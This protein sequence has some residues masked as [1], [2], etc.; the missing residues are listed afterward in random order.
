MSV[1]TEDLRGEKTTE[2]RQIGQREN[3]TEMETD[4]AAINLRQDLITGFRMSPSTAQLLRTKLLK[5]PLSTPSDW[6]CSRNLAPTPPSEDP[7]F[8]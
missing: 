4:F 6:P 7:Q 5:H 3:A 8:N 1:T 2:G